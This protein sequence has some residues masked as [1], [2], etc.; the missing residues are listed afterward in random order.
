M[1]YIVV[2]R[3]IARP[4]AVEDFK[5]GMSQKKREMKWCQARTHVSGSNASLVQ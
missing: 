4:K 1:G 2:E 3:K 5:G